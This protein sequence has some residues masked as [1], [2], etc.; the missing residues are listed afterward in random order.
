VTF[1]GLV[2]NEH[3]DLILQFLSRPKPWGPTDHFNRSIETQALGFE[4]WSVS[5]RSGDWQGRD[6]R[7]WR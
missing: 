2:D 1:D 7:A 5:P 6:W 4:A 3:I